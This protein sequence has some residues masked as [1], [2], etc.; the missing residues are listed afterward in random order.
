MEGLILVGKRAIAHR[1]VGF[2]SSLGKHIN[3]H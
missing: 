1:L 3:M 2:I